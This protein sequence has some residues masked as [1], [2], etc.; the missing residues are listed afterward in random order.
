MTEA[1]CDNNLSV[2][3]MLEDEIAEDLNRKD[4]I[5]IEEDLITKSPNRVRVICPIFYKCGGCDFLH[6][7]Y[8]EQLRMKQQYLVDLFSQNHIKTEIRPIIENPKPLNYRHKIVASATTVNHKLRL[9]LYR[10]HSKEVLPYLKCHIQDLDANLVLDETEK[11]LNQYR[12]PAY[13]LDRHI[14]IIK[15]IL[16]RKSYA[17]K[18]MLVVLVTQGNLLPNGKKIASE[19]MKSFPKIKGV[20]QNIHHKRM[21]FVLMEDEKLLS[22]SRFIEDRID[23]IR[24]RLSAQSFYQVNPI[25]M[26]KL[27]QKALDLAEIKKTDIVLDTYSGIGTISLLAALRAQEVIAIET[28]LNAHQDAIF[29]MKSNQINHITFINGNVENQIQRINQKIDILIMDPT[30][31]GASKA[32]LDAVIQLKP[33]K[34]IYISCEPKTQVRDLKH[35]LKFYQIKTLQPVD[36]F[37][38]TVHIEAIAVLE[39]K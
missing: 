3:Y 39:L 38:Q 6:I 9:G 17:T 35:L 32:F 24:F 30:R 23:D 28:N 12:I 16:I 31:D 13:D 14:G 29:N 1:I 4:H 8:N 34:V 10:E 25:Q 20:I 33:K 21:K 19:L 27:Y 2:R 15:H 36:M 37:S 11:L 5:V 18:E 7:N 22:G 26:I